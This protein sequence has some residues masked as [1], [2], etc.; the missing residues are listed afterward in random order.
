VTGVINAPTLRRDGSLLCEEGYDAK[1][2]L[3]LLNAPPVSIKMKPTRADA[4]AA[5]ETLRGLISETPFVDA[6]GRAV[7][8]SLILTIILRGALETSPLHIFVSPTAGSG[9]S[10]VVDIANLIATGRRCAVVAATGISEELEKRLGAAML[11]GRPL[12]SLDNLDGELSSN[13]LCQAVSQPV[14][15]FRPLGASVE[16]SLTTRSVFAATGNNLTIADDLGRRTIMARLDGAWNGFG[17]VSFRK[18][19]WN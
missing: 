2:G 1:T 11:S 3:L 7:A 6:A 8:L 5:I 13:L 10:Y 15:S 19:R 17:T 18:S 4:E 14:V 16:V 9:K 12:I